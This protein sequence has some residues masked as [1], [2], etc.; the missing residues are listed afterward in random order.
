MGSLA[1]K[2]ALVTGGSKGIGRA[3]ALALARAGA[4]VVI[5]HLGD[6]GNAASAEHAILQMGRRGLAVEADVANEA[7]AVRLVAKAVEHL[8][9]LDVLVASAGIN[10]LTPLLETS[11][12]DFDRIVGVN[13]RGLFLVGR[14]GAG[15][16]MRQGTGGRIINVASELAYLG[17]AG[18]SVYCASKGGVLSLTRS[19]ARELAPSILVNAIAP[20]P[21]DTDLLGWTQ[22]SAGERALE[23]NAV[24]LGRIGQPEEI[25]GVAV[26]LA[27]P[28]A[29][30]ITGQCYGVN[31]GAV[32]T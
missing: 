7:A 4:D 15:V 10:K 6:A 29:S 11:A 2:R 20:G 25:A 9:G 18:H 19:W 28:D 24:V 27:G 31:G 12:A 32:M 23:E 22:L 30:Y 8:G 14:E 26:F 16:M 5:G 13:L 17:R 1:G 21:V 3:I